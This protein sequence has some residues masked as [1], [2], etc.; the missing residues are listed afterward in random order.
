MTIKNWE[1][2][3]I[4]LPDTWNPDFCLILSGQESI[5]EVK[6]GP[7]GIRTTCGLYNH[8]YNRFL[9]P[10]CYLVWTF[11]NLEDYCLTLSGYFPVLSSKHTNLIA[12]V[13]KVKFE[14]LLPIWSK[15]ICSV[16][17]KLRDSPIKK[18]A[19]INK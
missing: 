13:L 10:H 18:S 3:V 9:D 12:F 6:T 14:Q 2:V 19:K 11:M 7:F 15:N 16:V 4:Q 8:R 5:F 17:W 1:A